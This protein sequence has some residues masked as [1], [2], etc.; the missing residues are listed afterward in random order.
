[1]SEALP[2]PRAGAASAP[3][4][5]RHVFV[6]DLELEAV[7]GVHEHEKTAPQRVII[8]LDLAVEEGPGPL[9][10]DLRHVV[11]YETLTRNVEAIVARGHVHL[12]E[13]LAEMIADACLEDPRVRAA[14]VRIEKPDAIPRARS[15]GIEIERTR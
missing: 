14:R 11:C 8:N 10:D 9:E 6:R 4:R 2:F 5:L 7:L 13:T 12:V 15:V 1:M 3:A